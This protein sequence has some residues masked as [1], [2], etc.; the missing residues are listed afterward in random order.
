MTA[1]KAP[2]AT[3]VLK[4]AS[5]EMVHQSAGDLAGYLLD[6]IG[7]RYTAVGL[8]LS[9]ARQIKAW[10]DQHASPRDRDRILRGNRCRVPPIGQP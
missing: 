8:G 6:R 7:P 3:T 2:T 1:I 9:D 10:R 4:E 5:R